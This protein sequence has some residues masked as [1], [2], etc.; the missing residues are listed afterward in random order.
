SAIR[1]Q[2]VDVPVDVVRVGT[3]L[4]SFAV[5]SDRSRPILSGVSLDI[6]NEHVRLTAT[7][8]YR[9]ALLQLPGNPGAKAALRAILP[10]RSL[11][12]LQKIAEGAQ[13]IRI[14]MP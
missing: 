7:D 14:G 9:L 13:V 10:P 6:T 5:S 2:G 3:D 11:T 1:Y 12:V 4:V 8:T